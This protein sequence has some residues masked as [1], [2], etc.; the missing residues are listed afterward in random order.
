M[1]FF[2]RSE[3]QPDSS[4]RETSVIF[5]GGGTNGIKKTYDGQA[6]KIGVF[7]VASGLYGVH[8]EKEMSDVFGIQVGAGLTGRNFMQGLLEQDSP[9]ND[10]GSTYFVSPNID[11]SDLLYNFDSRSG[12]MGYFLALHPK[13]YYEE[14]GFD[15]PYF[16]FV[17]QY[18]QYN[19]EAWGVNTAAHD[20]E[21]VPL[22]K[23]SEYENQTIFALSW[24][25]QRTNSKTALDTHLAIGVRNISGMRRDTGY[26]YDPLTLNATGYAVLSEEVKSQFYIELSFK[27][28]MWWSM[29]NV[30]K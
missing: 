23:I 27:L 29:A 2:I 30:K 28:G 21:Y 11:E 4:K 1:F 25:H 24:G 10:N 16:G 14:D 19:F 6:I 18:R 26:L 20:I 12:K 22:I 7:D 15:G 9:S 8:Y 3:G 13:F 5:F 17:F